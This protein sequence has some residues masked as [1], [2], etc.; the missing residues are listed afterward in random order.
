MS[1]STWA[2]S[3]VSFGVQYGTGSG[4]YW[5]YYR[6]IDDPNYTNAVEVYNGGA[7]NNYSGVIE[8]PETVTHS[9]VTYTVCGVAE[10]AFY[11]TRTDGA[12]TSV[13]LPT[14]VH[15][16][17]NRA[18]Y[19][20]NNMTTVNIPSA[21]TSI[22]SQAF[23][24]CRKLMQSDGVLIIPNA[25]TT[26]GQYA[27]Q[28]CV[29][30]SNVTIGTG[31]TTIGDGAFMGCTG[32]ATI[33]YNA[34]NCT[35]YGS[36][37]WS[38]CTHTPCTLNIGNTV[39]SLPNSAFSGYSAITTLNF[40]ATSQLTTIGERAFCDCT[41]IG[42]INIPNSVTSLGMEAFKNCSA[43]T[44]L[45]IGSGLETISKG[46][47]NNCSGLTS[48]I[49]PSNV[50]TLEGGDGI[51]VG[52]FSGCTGLTSLVIPDNLE[53]LGRE[54][55][56][57]C[58]NLE[59]VTIGTGVTYIGILV[60]TGC[61]KLEVVNY[62]VTDIPNVAEISSNYIWS[63][64]NHDCT[65]NIGDNVK[66]LPHDIFK[67]FAHLKT[68][69]FG[70]H[71]NFSIGSSAFQGCTGLTTL[72]IPDNVTTL[73]DYAFDGC[74]G[75]T[76]VNIG[77]GLTTIGSSAF[78]GCNNITSLDLGNR[79]ERIERDAFRNCT[80]LA[81]IIIPATVNYIGS[82]D[83]WGNTGAFE[84]CTGLT[85]IWFMGAIKPSINTF[86][87]DGIDDDNVT[88]Y[89]PKG[90]STI[91]HFTHYKYFLRFVG[92]NNI[93]N[94]TVASNWAGASTYTNTA[95]PTSDE[96]VVIDGN[97]DPLITGD[98][99]VRPYKIVLNNGRK[100]IIDGGSQ[101]VYDEPIQVTAI[102]DIQL[103]DDWTT[104]SDGW[105]FIASP[106]N[107]NLIPTEVDG[108]IT[109]DNEVGHTFDLY[110]YD[111]SA[112]TYEGE[113]IPWQNYRNPLH[114]A[115]FRIQN[116]AGY[117]YANSSDAT[118]EFTGETKAFN[119]SANN[120]IT[121]EH[122]GWNLIGNPFT[123]TVYPDC[124]IATLNHAN[125]VTYTRSD[126]AVVK[127]CEGFAVHGTEGTEVVLYRGIYT[128]P[129]PNQN[130]SL[131]MLL[132]N[133]N[134]RD[135]KPIDNVIV[136]FSEGNG[137]PKFEF[138]EQNAKLYIPQNGKDYAIAYSNGHG[139]MPLNFKAKEM[140]RYTISF[141]TKDLDLSYLH[142]IDRFT[143]ENIDLLLDNE[144]S[145]IASNNDS[146]NRFILSFGPST[147]SSTD[148]NFAFQN[149][150]EIIV[151]GEGELQMFDVTGRMIAAQ[152]VDGVETIA[153]PSQTGVYIMK[154]NENIQKIV[155][156]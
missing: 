77:N 155:V 113:P 93:N 126:Q 52:A 141:E 81:T 28:A 122:D 121:L 120:T 23:F 151:S 107:V 11:D 13:S 87:F 60:F 42:A 20:C 110:R 97:N 9:D 62:N 53:Y 54:S 24:D 37:V 46:A 35:S 142:L 32:L 30:L 131:N 15:Y 69:N 8:V 6:V 102:K 14:T 44:T 47:F 39:Q 116:G 136:N 124:D 119:T 98:I 73:D 55:F 134:V 64:S 95:A 137:M 65:V 56:S 33:N 118:I 16:I 129:A 26:I 67:G 140:G 146:E 123:F 66:G 85:E 71:A 74:T 127:P 2:Q 51:R 130:N 78:Q 80:G 72:T 75:L 132:T 149:G 70:S 19:H 82:A 152:R 43:A 156:R 101:L 88:V 133:A 106:I 61:S 45:S 154:L 59:T 125:G 21:V 27:F 22:G 150:D 153:K 63:G 83:G 112:V 79:V 25:V 139:T 84:N 86:A 115:G 57:G 58:S 7:Y 109:A 96:V 10:E 111:E 148:S 1:G 92:G 114:T 117:L 12:V 108:L 147:G 100:I 36:S 135:A 104:A 4:A 50:T 90:Y 29:A 89:A 31:V 17:G 103:A 49:I 5:I 143:G 38:G 138:G 34:A 99:A 48:L 105:Y 41:H 18:F 94:W 76:T 91:S 3:V 68:I 145:F 144:Y 40:V 128:S